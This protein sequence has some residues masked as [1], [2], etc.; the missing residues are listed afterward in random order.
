MSRTLIALVV[1][2]AA[3]G[4]APQASSASPITVPTDLSPGD[5]YRLAFVTSTSRD[6]LSSDIGQYNSFVSLVAGAVPELAAL[7]TTW[8]AIGST[9]SVDARD[10]TGTNPSSTG[11]PIYRLDDTRIANDNADLWDGA[12]FA[13]MNIDESGSALTAA[14]NVWTGT[15]TDGGKFGSLELGASP[16]VGFGITGDTSGV[17]ILQSKTDPNTLLPLYA[18]S[19]EITVVPEPGTITLGCFGAIAV[20]AWRLGRRRRRERQ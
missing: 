18:I 7:G 17:W 5:T 4:V 15:N 6:A 9:V 10:N 3:F 14:S 20:V 19:G 12:I 8:K 13:V 2:W 11:V 1:L 16:L